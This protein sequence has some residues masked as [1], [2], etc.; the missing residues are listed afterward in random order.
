[1]GSEVRLAATHSPLVGDR[2]RSVTFVVDTSEDMRDLLASAKRLLI[3]T[4]LRK[5]AFRDSLF[6]IVTFSGQV[7]LGN[8]A[9]INMTSE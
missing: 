7:T 6:N 4:L 2:G 9:K 5:A 1:M 8:T 3:G